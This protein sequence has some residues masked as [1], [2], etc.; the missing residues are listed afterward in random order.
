MPT[1]VEVTGPPIGG[2]TPSGL[3]LAHD[4]KLS[5]VTTVDGAPLPLGAALVCDLRQ[6]NLNVLSDA[7]RAHARSPW[8]PMA[9]V[10]PDGASESV[11]ESI[12]PG[13]GR[14]ATLALRS[15]D[16]RPVFG[17][18][19]VAVARRGPPDRHAVVRYIRSRAD[20]QLARAVAQSLEG[21][22]AWSTGLRRRLG[23][24]D[25]PSPNHWLNVFHLANCLSSAAHPDSRTL[26]QVAFRFDRAPRTL[27]SWCAKYL[28]CTWPEARQRLG[29]E[30]MVEAVL[31]EIPPSPLRP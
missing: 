30:W 15:Q 23:R 31:R 9:V 4:G 25:A 27:S 7:F 24:L 12:R 11:L 28:R 20:E 16:I 10:L 2:R 26:E 21:P 6:T 22:D 29:W 3:L 19:S 17:A 8:C 13:L 5:P 1:R 18:I 14:S